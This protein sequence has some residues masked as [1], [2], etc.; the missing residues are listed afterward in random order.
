MAEYNNDTPLFYLTVGQFRQL[1]EAIYA[2]GTEP[3]LVKGMA[4]IMSIFDCSRSTAER[5][6]RSGLIDDA[7]TQNTRSGLFQVDVEKARELYARGR[8]IVLKRK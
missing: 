7:I 4:G 5:I 1:C 8:Q 6:K 2:K 3:H